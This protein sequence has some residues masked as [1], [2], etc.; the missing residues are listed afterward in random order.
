MGGKHSVN[1]HDGKAWNPDGT[2]YTGKNK[3]VNSTIEALNKISSKEDGAQLVND[4][5][6]DD[7]LTEIME[8]E[9]KFEIN[10]KQQKLQWDPNNT[11]GGLDQ[12][13]GTPRPSFIGLAHELAHIHDKLDKIMDQ[14]VWF[15]MGKKQIY[16]YEKYSGHWE[17]KIRAEHG[18]PMREFY[19]KYNGTW[20][21]RYLIPGTRK[22][23]NYDH[24]FKKP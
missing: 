6:K 20:M 21:G 24:E 10:S 4:F 8:G 12:N 13:S 7:G 19:G 15:P 16:N 17:N 22:D 5:V 1:Y 3:F 11:S 18:I 14:N 2:E 23:A 9:N